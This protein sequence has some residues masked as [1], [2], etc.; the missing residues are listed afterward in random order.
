MIRSAWWLGVSACVVSVAL[1]ATS[2]RRDRV[3]TRRQAAN[4]NENREKNTAP[5]LTAPRLPPATAAQRAYDRARVTQVQAVVDALD[6]LARELQRLARRGAAEPAFRRRWPAA[7][8][9]FLRRV[10]VVRSQVVALDPLG[11]QSWAAQVATALV[12][13]LEVRL[14]D[15]V[16]ESWDSRPSGALRTWMSDFTLIWQGLRRYVRS[17]QNASE[18]GMAP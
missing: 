11:R 17:L 3:S 5:L 14:P 1:G 16:R 12:A 13:A 10:G 4:L 18:K 9:A 15:A 2:C 8:D 7:R 6:R